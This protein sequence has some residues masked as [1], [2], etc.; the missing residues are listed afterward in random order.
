MEKEIEYI[1]DEIKKL[2]Y[3]IA[4]PIKYNITPTIKVK[5][6]DSACYEYELKILNNIKQALTT[7]SK[8]EQAFDIIKEYKVDTW[9]LNQ[10]DYEN[11]IR[12]RK[13]ARVSIE[14]IINEDGESVEEEISYEEF[15]L[16]KEVLND[17]SQE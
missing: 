7:K 6:N 1:N 2:E 13:E 16:V 4:N 11:Y 17:N 12:I 9:L 5:I 14:Q 10:C 8:K 15:N 3:H